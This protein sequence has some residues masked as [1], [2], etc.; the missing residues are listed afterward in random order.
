MA[1]SGDLVVV[2]RVG[3]ARGVRG[4]VFVEPWTDAPAERFAPGS[5]LQAEPGPLTVEAA[6]SAGGRLV[7]HFAGVD[8]RAAAERLRGA[9]LAIPADTRPGL[10]DPDE[11]YDTE[12]VGLSAYTVDGVELG[13]VARVVHAGGASYLVLDLAGSE[14]LVPFVA[15]IVPTVDLEAGRV[16]VDPPEGL[17][18]L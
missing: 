6:S 10:D 15:A 14:R 12:L 1:D 4:D 18:E 3:P 17:L 13:P 11:Y 16:V 7:V 5:V 8:N 9:E 2:G